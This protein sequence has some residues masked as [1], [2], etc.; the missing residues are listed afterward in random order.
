MIAYLSIILFTVYN[1]YK[2]LGFLDFD[3]II[4]SILIATWTLRLGLFL[5]YRVYSDKVYE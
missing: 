2:I 4:I 5:F 3:S 1:K